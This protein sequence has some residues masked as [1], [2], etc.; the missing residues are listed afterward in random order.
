MSKNKLV[1]LGLL[2]EEPMYGYQ[3]DQVIKQRHMTAWA[4]ITMASIYNTLISLEIIGD[5]KVT[6]GRVGNM[7]ERKVYSITK[8]GKQSLKKLIIDGVEKIV[9]HHNVEFLLSVG[10]IENLATQTAIRSLGIRKQ[11]LIQKIRHID[12]VHRIHEK[13]I[14]FNWLYI[15]ETSIERFKIDLKGT[16]RL[17]EKIKRK[18]NLNWSKSMI[19]NIILMICLVS[20]AVPDIMAENP[21]VLSLKECL[22]I[23]IANNFSIQK[24]GFDVMISRESVVQFKSQYET[25]LNISAGIADSKNSGANLIFGSESRISSLNI[26]VAKKL[27]K[28]GGDLGLNWK[29]ERTDSDSIFF[30]INP[31]YESDIELSYRQPILKNSIG[32]NDKKSFE[33]FNINEKISNNIYILGKN[34]LI[35]SIEKSYLNLNFAKKNL[36]TQKQ[37]LERSKELFTINKMK[38]KDGLLEEVDVIATEAAIMIREAL[39]L[40]SDDR[41]KDAAENLKMLI[42]MPD[43]QQC[44]FKYEFPEEYEHLK[45][46]E[47]DTSRLALSQRTDLKII[48]EQAKIDLLRLEI[49]RNERLPDLDVITQFSVTNT[50]D[51]FGDNYKS[52]FRTENPTWYLGLNL[53]IFPLNRYYKTAYNI[54]EYKLLKTKAEFEGKKL[55]IVKESRSAA[56]HINTQAKFVEAT[57][58]AMELQ[59]RKLGLEEIKFNQGRSAIHII[60]TYQDDLSNAEIEYYAALTDYYKARADLVLITGEER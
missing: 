54:N 52:I 32:K 57:R 9:N 30:T 17:I 51:G 27:Y 47:N 13:K 45:I 48:L 58:K 34:N 33:I 41:V 26:A 59:K 25:G 55:S 28:T 19:K 39:I 20:T 23:G 46:N 1:V 10:F 49:N 5:I 22:K 43:N 8:T 11:K 56:R 3:M 21:M 36:Q 15:I 7:P 40:Q 24:S 53:E 38:L 60:L 2:S 12:E 35:N 14:P 29:N 18:N 16:K 50:A 44:T 4:R 6:K 42:G 31:S 37:S